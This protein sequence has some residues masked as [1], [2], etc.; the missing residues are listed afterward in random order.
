MK[1]R[2]ALLGVG[3]LLLIS[4]TYSSAGGLTS[5]QKA[6][7]TFYRAYSKLMA[8]EFVE[9][10]R[11]IEAALAQDPN[12]AYAHITRAEYAMQEQDW[13]TAQK[14]FE[15]GLTLLKEPNQPL[16]PR[17]DIVITPQEVE[18]DAHC[19]LGYVYVKLAQKASRSGDSGTEQK[20]LG[21]A[22]K[23]LSAGMKLKPGDEARELAEGLL[24]MF[25]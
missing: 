8:G 4:S 23:S 22:H 13:L 18:G 11:G 1:M 7:Q 15:R 9:G 20:Y 21:R 24:K 17:P 2:F 16:S 14:H 5:R 3:C 12:F 19:F 25:K 6:M 10:L